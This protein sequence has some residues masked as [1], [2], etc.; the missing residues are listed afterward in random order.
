MFAFV[1]LSLSVISL[2]TMSQRAPAS[3]YIYIITIHLLLGSPVKRVAVYTH[4]W[5]NEF[6]Y[7]ID[8]GFEVGA[9]VSYELRPTDKMLQW[10]A[11]CISTEFDF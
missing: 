7:V 5:T 2:Y 9:E 4:D 3:I 8:F 11:Q 10:P 6:S 1:S